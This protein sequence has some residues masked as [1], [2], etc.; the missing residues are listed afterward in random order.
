MAKPWGSKRIRYPCSPRPKLCRLAIGS[1]DPSSGVANALSLPPGKYERKL[2]TQRNRREFAQAVDHAVQF[3]T[4]R[5]TS[6]RLEIQL[7]APE[8]ESPSRVLDRCCTA[9]VSSSCEIIFASPYGNIWVQPAHIGEA[10]T[11]NPKGS[12]RQLPDDPLT[13]QSI[14]RLDDTR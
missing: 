8:T 14:N 1:I 2:K 12:L 11:G 9:V 4:E 5:G 7:Q 10:L 3:D 13:T 6:P